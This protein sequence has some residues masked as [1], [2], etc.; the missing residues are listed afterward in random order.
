MNETEQAKRLHAHP[1][2]EEQRLAIAREVEEYCHNAREKALA[3]AKLEEVLL[4]AIAAVARP[5][6]GW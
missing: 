4:W 6:D 1:I 3:D 5:G 2:R